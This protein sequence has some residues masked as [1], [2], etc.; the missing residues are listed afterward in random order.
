MAYLKDFRERIQHNDYPGFLK[1][2]EEYCYGD[3]PEGEEI[4]QVL[5]SIKAS[6]LAKPFGVHVDRVLALWRQLKGPEHT[7]EILRLLFDLQTTNS[8]ELADLGTNYLKERY[9]SDSLFQEKLKLIGLRT[10][11]RFTGAIR[12]FELLTHFQK[13][14]FVFHTAGWGTGEVLDV[15][16]LR[17]EVTVECE[18]V[19]GPQHFSFEKAF[20]T[21]VA[22]P[23]DHFCS[24]RFGDPDGLEREARDNPAE[25]IRMLLRDLGPKN[26]AEIKEELCELVIPEDDWNRWW[27]AA[28]TKIKKDT[29]IESPKEAKDRFRLRT[30]DVPHEV[31]LHKALEEKPAVHALIQIVHTFLRDFP[32]T[33]KNAEFRTSVAA[34]LQ[35]ALNQ[36]SISDSQRLQLLFLLD[37]LKVAGAH[38][39]LSALVGETK[40]LSE[41]IAQIETMAFQKRIVQEARKARKDW[42]ELYLELLFAVE[43]NVLRDFLLS[44]LEEGASNADLKKRINTLLVHPVSYPEQV[45][46]YFQKIIQPKSKLPLA[47]RTGKGSFF[48]SL[49]VLLD[50]LEQKPQQR[51]LAKKILALLTADRYKIVRDIFQEA[52]EAEIREYLLLATKCESF[53]DHDI[54]I[55]H[56]LAE[57]VHPNLSRLRKS[58]GQ[59]K[60]DDAIFWATEKGYQKTQQRV[61]QIATV[62]TVQNAKEI[63]TARGHGDLRENAEF[64]AALERRSRLQSELKFLSDQLAKARIL[65]PEDVSVDE[66]GIGTVV[67]CKDSKGKHARYTILGPWEAD[68]ETRILSLQS[69]LAQAMKGRTVGEKFDFQGDAFTITA[70]DNYFDQKE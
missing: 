14:N 37:D 59:P 12:N 52:E 42:K 54:K 62:E 8:E 7:H 18:Y 39:K 56:S 64:K 48:E 13:G 19:V 32:E 40:N 34:R 30:E 45:V 44:E 6:E 31:A 70:I 29:K 3:Q 49:L 66:V 10:R 1:I 21:L 53:T 61:Q 2:W 63:E 55:L 17:E 60:Q 26:A 68:P 38:E 24:R 22:L 41:V 16:Y 47:D 69:K 43:Q 35:E 27:Q 57:V 11:E 33:L 5:E 20:K 25:V 4:V 15:S 65:T 46:W 67:H 9:P 28:R 23:K 50:H 36:D 51:D 58:K